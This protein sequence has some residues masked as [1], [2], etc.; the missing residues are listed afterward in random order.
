M[1]KYNIG[2]IEQLA[3]GDPK[4]ANNRIY[5]LY[6][7]HNPIPYD[8]HECVYLWLQYRRLYWYL[9]IAANMI[10][11]KWQCFINVPY[12]LFIVYLNICCD[13]FQT[14]FFHQRSI[15][16]LF[17]YSLMGKFQRDWANR[18]TKKNGKNWNING[19]NLNEFGIKWT[20]DVST[21]I[22]SVFDTSI[23]SSVMNWKW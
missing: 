15:C 18:P 11:S 13:V 1:F 12:R 8:K 6:S 20:G 22:D 7:I 19:I 4:R 9:C 17:F 3:Q 5:T 10:H 21:L 14:W 23:M 16:F 2:S